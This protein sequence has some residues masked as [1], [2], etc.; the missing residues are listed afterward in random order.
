[1]ESRIGETKE[2]LEIPAKHF[3]ITLRQ[4]SIDDAPTIFNL[5]NR[6]REHLSRPWDDTAD[7]YK[8]LTSVEESILHPK[9]EDRKRFGIWNDQGEYVGTIN[10][11]PDE[12]NP[13]RAE[14][15][16]YLGKESTGHG[17]ILKSLLTLSTWAFNNRGIDEVY[18]KID[19]E[20]IPSSKVATKANF[21]ETGREINEKRRTDIVFTL[22]K[23][24]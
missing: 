17:Y 11:T 4:F 20:N 9:N 7:K 13:K 2:K 10:I 12:D 21:K 6:N 8:T 1:M 16:Y 22:V 3:G 18:L 5:I 15:G 14:I 23:P 24:K 19:S